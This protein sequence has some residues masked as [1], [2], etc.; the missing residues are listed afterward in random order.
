MPKPSLGQIFGNNASVSATGELT[1]KFSDFSNVGWDTAAG[2]TDAEKWLTAILLKA[3]AFSVSNTDQ[4][5]NVVVQEPYPGL[6]TRN[7]ELKRE[8]SYNVQ[9]Y[10]TDTG[11]N[12]PD[13][14]LI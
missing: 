10:V 11:T 2:T 4:L 7:N 3:R 12:V 8:Y 6:L 5:P 9:I 13:P 14:D 1:I